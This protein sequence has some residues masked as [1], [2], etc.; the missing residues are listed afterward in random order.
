[1]RIHADMVHDG[2]HSTEVKVRIYT[3]TA[4]KNSVKIKGR[5]A[6]YNCEKLCIESMSNFHQRN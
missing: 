5:E 6:S 1:M 3:T 4:H 2:D